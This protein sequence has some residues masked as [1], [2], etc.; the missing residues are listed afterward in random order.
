M[1]AHQNTDSGEI[2]VSLDNEGEIALARVWYL[3]IRALQR[4]KQPE[5]LSE[6]EQRWRE[7]NVV[8]D[9][10]ESWDAAEFD[11][12]VAELKSRRNNP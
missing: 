5:K 10:P 2:F 8:I 7:Q 1:K 4:I 6:Q 3:K 12:A 11:A 9:D